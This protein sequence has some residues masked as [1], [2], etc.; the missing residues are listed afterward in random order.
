MAVSAG[1]LIAWRT[2]GLVIFGRNG[3]SQARALLDG[4]NCLEKGWMRA[5]YIVAGLAKLKA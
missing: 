3:K 1:V 4:T 5:H 2:T